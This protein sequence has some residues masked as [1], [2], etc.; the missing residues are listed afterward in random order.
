MQKL[1]HIHTGFP[2]LSSITCKSI[3]KGTKRELNFHS[4]QTE[5]IGQV[6]QYLIITLVLSG[7]DLACEEQGKGGE[8]SE[9]NHDDLFGCEIGRSIVNCKTVMKF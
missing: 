5:I 2:E 6:C 8:V 4:T 7:L 9:A 3:C 1:I